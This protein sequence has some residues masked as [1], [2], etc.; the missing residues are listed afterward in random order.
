MLSEI[1]KTFHDEAF[2]QALLAA[3]TREALYQQLTA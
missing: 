2:R 3:K 1:A